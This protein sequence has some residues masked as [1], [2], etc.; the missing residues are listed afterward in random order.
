MTEAHLARVLIDEAGDAEIDPKIKVL[1]TRIMHQ[2]HSVPSLETFLVDAGVVPMD[3]GG[4][5]IQ[6][7]FLRLPEEVVPQIERLLTADFFRQHRWTKYVKNGQAH[8]GFQLILRP[9]D[10]PGDAYDYAY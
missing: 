4:A 3:N 10:L 5:D 1:M 8:M 9:D 2:I 7:D 6:L